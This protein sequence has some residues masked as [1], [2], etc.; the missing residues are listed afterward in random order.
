VETLNLC[1]LVR[2]LWPVEGNQRFLV[3]IVMMVVMAT[4]MSPLLKS[5]HPT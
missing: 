3:L 5:G 1:L 4:M 2:F